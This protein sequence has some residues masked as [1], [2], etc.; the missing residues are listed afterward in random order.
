MYLSEV[1]SG[2]F[3]SS[4]KIGHLQRGDRGDI[5]LD[6][7]L[8]FLHLGEQGWIANNTG[9][10]LDFPARFIQSRNHTHD[11]ALKNVSQVCDAIK[12]HAPRPFVYHF[13][14][15]KAWPANEIVRVAA[16]KDHLMLGLDGIDT[17]GYLNNNVSALSGC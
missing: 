16:G 6:H 4:F 2:T 1:S 8:A 12:R 10:V 9:C 3:M 17:L 13:Y 14:E 7:L 11:C 5:P 15:A